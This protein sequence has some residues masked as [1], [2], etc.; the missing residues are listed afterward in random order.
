MLTVV[1]A[2][3]LPNPME[4]SAAALSMIYGINMMTWVQSTVRQSI[5]CEILLASA[6]R[7][8]EYGRLPVE[9]DDKGKGSFL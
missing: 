8:D 5:E 7:I 1:I 6:E 3:I 2:V 9:E 4:Q